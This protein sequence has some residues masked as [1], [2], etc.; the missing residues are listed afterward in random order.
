MKKAPKPINQ[1]SI[2]RPS[3]TNSVSL[4]NFTKRISASRAPLDKKR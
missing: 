1:V 3:G 2:Y 4:Q